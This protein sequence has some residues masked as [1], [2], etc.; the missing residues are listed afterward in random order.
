MHELQLMRQVVSKV[1]EVCQTRPGTH[2]S[3]IR[4]E[5][6]SHSHMAGH[7]PEE[8]QATFRL[9]AQKTPIQH[10]T[11]D[12]RI[13]PSHGTCRTCRRLTE[14]GPETLVCAHCSS[15]HVSWDDPPELVVKD[16]VL[17]EPSE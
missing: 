16:L 17:L 13:L 9:A 5:I 11:L 6:S 1:H 3:L 15:E 8:L 10:A 7:T 4:L 14:R 12:I 2:L